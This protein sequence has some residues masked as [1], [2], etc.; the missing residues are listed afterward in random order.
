MREQ[1]RITTQAAAAV[2]ASPRQSRIVQTLIGEPLTLADL[3]RLTDTPLNLLHYHVNKCI[4]L[5]LIRIA[6]AKPRAGRAMKYYRASARSFFVPAELIS[7]WPGAERTQDLRD[8][9][10]RG[11]ARSIEGVNFT[12]NGMHPC[13]LLVKDRAATSHAVEL[14]LDVG[15]SSAD[16][17]T[18]FEDLRQLLERYR[19]RGKEG[20]PNYLVHLAAVRRE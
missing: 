2:F 18:L 12:H 6:H 9:L 15:L 5:G 13:I 3:A 19:A 17:V 16:A 14:W 11:N 20:E 1:F 8:T 4:K 10:D 7:E